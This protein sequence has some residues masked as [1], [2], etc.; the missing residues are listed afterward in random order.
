MIMKKTSLISCINITL[1]FKNQSSEAPKPLV[2]KQN[3]PVVALKFYKISVITHFK[4]Y[5]ISHMKQIL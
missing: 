3:F 1:L 4:T 5:N 2:L